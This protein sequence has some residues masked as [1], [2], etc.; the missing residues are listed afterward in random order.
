[1]NDLAA[2][3]ATLAEILRQPSPIAGDDD[4]EALA[5]GIAKGNER[6]S[7]AE[8]I[9]IY[10]EQF[11]LRHVDVLREDFRAIEHL[12]GRADFEALAR[13]YLGAHPP[14]SYTLRDLGHAMAAFVA[15]APPW[16]DDPF[17]LDLARLEWAFVEAFDGRDVPPLD[18]SVVAN[19]PED[20]WPGAQIAL[21]PSVQRLALAHPA[22]DYRQAVHAGG[23]ASRPEPRPSHVVVYRGPELL[24]F[25]EVEADAFAMLDDLARGATLGEACERAAHLEAKLAGWFQQWTALG[26]VC[27]VRF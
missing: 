20:A 3:Q 8:Q 26:W 13:A 25:I 2:I 6:L 14:A 4:R 12:L 9:D 1:M 27:A 18:A 7:P 5:A 15:S 16:K 22:H 17:V 24:H 21:H 23:G 10:R 19:A 11:F